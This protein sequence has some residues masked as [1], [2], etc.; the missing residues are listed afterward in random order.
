MYVDIFGEMMRMMQKTSKAKRRLSREKPE[1]RRAGKPFLVFKEQKE[2]S[3]IKGILRSCSA[4]KRV[5]LHKMPS[6]PE[7][8]ERERIVLHRRLRSGDMKA[9]I[10]EFPGIVSFPENRES[11]VGVAHS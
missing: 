9:I 11:S 4:E 1:A 3:G 5:H 2:P 7:A 8:V 6:D 10:L